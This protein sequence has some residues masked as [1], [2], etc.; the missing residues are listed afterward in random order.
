MSK[1]N[2]KLNSSNKGKLKEFQYFFKQ[3]KYELEISTEDLK[4]IDADPLSIVVHK[5][6]QLSEKTLV[7]DTSLEIEGEKIGTNI[8]WLLD[9]LKNFIGKKAEWVV[10]LA[11]REGSDIYVFK[12]SVKGTI[13]K[14]RGGEGFGFDPY[15]QPDTSNQTLA[16]NKPDHL[17]AR[18]LA[19]KNFINNNVFIKRSVIKDWKGPW[20]Y[21]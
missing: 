16:Q 20:Q 9:Y 18:G 8:R 7:E 15:F 3:Y 2:W 10:L 19:I 14:E 5:A 1:S 12:G 6:S 17:N 13:V 11:Y 21:S 4:E